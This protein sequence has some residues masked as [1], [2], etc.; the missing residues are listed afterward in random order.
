MG[1][2]SDKSGAADLAGIA[3]DDLDMLNQFGATTKKPAHIRLRFAK[4]LTTAAAATKHPVL[5]NLFRGQADLLQRM[6]AWET[7]RQLNDSLAGNVAVPVC[8]DAIATITETGLVTIGTPYNGQ[9]WQLVDILVDPVNAIKF[10]CTQFNIAGINFNQ[11]GGVTYA[12]SAPTSP[13]F[14]M[15]VWAYNKVGRP[16][17]MFKP[18]AGLAF[19]PEGTLT[20]KFYNSTAS[21]ASCDLIF[22]V[23]S[24]PCE[25]W[26]RNGASDGGI[27]QNASGTLAN[28]AAFQ[29]A[30]R[31]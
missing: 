19:N 15:S 27:M 5:K 9:P 22:L 3:D 14:S 10:R 6:H 30:H 2:K 11:T 18:W 26:G 13:G 20:A 25:K 17:N 28:L 29:I 12:S 4:K 23:R 24:S 7:M 8:L 21:T 1:F 16:S 31:A